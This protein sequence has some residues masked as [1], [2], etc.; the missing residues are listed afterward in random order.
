MTAPTTPVGASGA[1]ASSGRPRALATLV[2]VVALLT[3]IVVGMAADRRLPMRWRGAF[4]GHFMAGR[5]P[6]AWG[7]DG[8]GGPD[9]NRGG[10]GA[11]ADRMHQRFATELGLTPAQMAQ[12]DSIMTRSMAERRTIED[13]VRPR[14]RTIAQ[15]DRA[16]PD[17]RPAPEVRSLAHPQPPPELARA[18]SPYWARQLRLLRSHP[19]PADEAGFVAGRG[20]S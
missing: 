3:G 20:R 12:V 1:S 11:S 8:R 4:G 19:T 10:P 9:G 2:V 18:V 7:G 6:R 5:G 16:R 15:P 17:P 14:L 13:S